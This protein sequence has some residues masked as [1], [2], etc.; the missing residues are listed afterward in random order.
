[1]SLVCGVKGGP[2][3]PAGD[4]I[5]L[6]CCWVHQT[7][8]TWRPSTHF[9]RTAVCLKCLVPD[10]GLSSPPPQR[11]KSGWGWIGTPFPQI[12]GATGPVAIPGCRQEFHAIPCAHGNLEPQVMPRGPEAGRVCQCLIKCNINKPRE[13]A[14]ATAGW[15]PGT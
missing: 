9:I 10:V 8:L 1:M 3:P 4:L 5:F 11:K 14:L 13:S 7:G 12:L 2:A 6:L 15:L